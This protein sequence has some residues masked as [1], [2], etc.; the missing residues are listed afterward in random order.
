MEQATA[1]NEVPAIAVDSMTVLNRQK[2]PKAMV[3]VKV[4]GHFV[5][6]GLAVMQAARGGRYVA[7]P[8]TENKGKRWDTFKPITKAG[9][10]AL[11]SAVMAEYDKKAK[12][13]A[14][15]GGGGNEK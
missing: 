13:Q 9:Q 12:I 14:A 8:T 15:I 10:E 3:S 2:N 11:K 6:S 7:M 4:G 5:V 1:V